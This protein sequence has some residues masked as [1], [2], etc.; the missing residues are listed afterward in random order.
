M[1]ALPF[2]LAVVLAGCH[3]D[4]LSPV[5]RGYALTTSADVADV[6]EA[7][8]RVA[9]D[10]G[11]PARVRDGVVEVE[12]PVGGPMSERPSRRLD[13][14]VRPAGSRVVVTVRELSRVDVAVT[15]APPHRPPDWR[16]R[17]GRRE[18]AEPSLIAHD[19]ADRLSRELG[20]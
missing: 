1:R 20:R 11:Y 19:F 6:H 12:V 2:A 14:A 17:G 10:L 13:V 9:A 4:R 5:D 18:R 7:A 16:P 15:H 3:A 8:L